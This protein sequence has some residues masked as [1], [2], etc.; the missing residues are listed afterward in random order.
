L[1]WD[2]VAAVATVRTVEAQTVHGKE[3]WRGIAAKR[4]ECRRGEGVWVAKELSGI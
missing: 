2:L 4:Y 3:Y 1:A